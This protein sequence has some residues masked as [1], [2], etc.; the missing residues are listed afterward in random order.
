M[1]QWEFQAEEHD[2]DEKMETSGPMQI[3]L[4]KCSTRQMLIR[5]AQFE[6][7][8]YDEI[9]KLD[10]YY[11]ECEKLWKSKSRL[12]NSELNKNGVAHILSTMRSVYWISKRE[13]KSNEI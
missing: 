8:N 10:L 2:G 9:A 12:E 4:L 6:G 1:V 5:Q 7:I 11:D 3:C 13:Q